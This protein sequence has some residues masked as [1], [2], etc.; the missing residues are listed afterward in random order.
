MTIKVHNV[1]IGGIVDKPVNALLRKLIPKIVWPVVQKQLNKHL[2]EKGFKLPAVCGLTFNNSQIIYLDQD[3]VVCT[4]VVYDLDGF[5]NR[6]TEWQRQQN[7]MAAKN[8]T[9]VASDETTVTAQA[10]EEVTVSEVEAE[11]QT[12]T[13]RSIHVLSKS[14]DGLTL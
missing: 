1:G 14:G 13:S 9:T 7:E 3:V 2:K 6:F 4:D 12:T 11:Q 8:R 5:L 10:S